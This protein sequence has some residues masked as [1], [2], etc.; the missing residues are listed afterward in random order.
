MLADA[1]GNLGAGAS[2]LQGLMAMVAKPGKAS[3]IGDMMQYLPLL[4]EFMGS[5]QPTNGGAPGAL[6][7]SQQS[8]QSNIHIG[9]KI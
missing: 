4:K 5:Q 2:G 6:P 1:V 9:G 3:G 7:P 8:P